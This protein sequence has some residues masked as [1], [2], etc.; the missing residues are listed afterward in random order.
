MMKRSWVVLLVFVFGIA[1][2]A[3]PQQ[4]GN[5]TAGFTK[6]ETEFYEA[7]KQ[8]NVSRLDQML[9]P[10]YVLVTSA[11]AADPMDR[12]S[13]LDLIAV[14]NVESFTVGD[15]VV[16][17]LVPRGGAGEACDLA[18]VSLVIT[19]K[20]IVGG[21]DRSTDGGFIVDIWSHHNGS[22]QLFSRYAS[23]KS[24]SSRLPKVM[25]PRQSQK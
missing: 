13:W 7:I 4:S 2:V 23:T 16:R 18:A 5:L 21:E 3:A 25:Q 14:Y 8:K 22:W 17:C 6:L 19:Q 11:R 12:K 20:A 1:G 24:N 15:V 9:A 10:D